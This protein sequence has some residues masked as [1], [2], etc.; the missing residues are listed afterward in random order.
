MRNVIL[1]VVAPSLEIATVTQPIELLAG[2]NEQLFIA[3]VKPK[4]DS[5]NPINMT[6]TFE[7]EFG[8]KVRLS[9][10]ITV[11]T[12]KPVA[13]PPTQPSPGAQPAGTTAAG[14]P[15]KPAQP[16]TAQ[17]PAAQPSA[18]QPAVDHTKENLFIVLIIFGVIGAAAIFLILNSHKDHSG[19]E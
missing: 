2:K 6:L 3:T 17:Q 18:P 16:S 14:Q 15:A 19:E 12:G 11:I 4:D 7:T 8:D 1:S 5:R 9:K 13:P 10:N